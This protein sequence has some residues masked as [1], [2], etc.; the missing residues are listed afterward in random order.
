M[1]EQ[2]GKQDRGRTRREMIRDVGMTA[3]VFPL[4]PAMASADAVEGTTSP[5]VAQAGQ[6]PD[7]GDANYSSSSGWHFGSQV[8]HHGEQNGYQVTPISQDKL[9]GCP[10]PGGYLSS[11]RPKIPRS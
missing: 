2:V 9:P 5:A 1:N 8:I 3:A 6:L 4:L 10:E 7:I 11:V